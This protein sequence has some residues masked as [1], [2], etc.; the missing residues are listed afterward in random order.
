MNTIGMAF[1]EKQFQ[2]PPTPPSINNDG[3]LNAVKKK[4]TNQLVRASVKYKVL[5]A[6]YNSTIFF[7]P[8]SPQ[9]N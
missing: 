8:P 7:S 1:G 3:S 2:S 6:N 9:I 5:L 4:I